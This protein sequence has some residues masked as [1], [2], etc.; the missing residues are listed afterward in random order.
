MDCFFCRTIIN[1]LDPPINIII[2]QQLT[3]INPIKYCS[4]LIQ[5]YCFL[6]LSFR[7]E[8][9]LFLVFMYSQLILMN[10]FFYQNLPELLYT[11]VKI[12]KVYLT[13]EHICF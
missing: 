5:F 8:Y 9:K 1:F 11:T 2:P 13:L 7:L 4:K 3:N 6:K 12:K 10:L